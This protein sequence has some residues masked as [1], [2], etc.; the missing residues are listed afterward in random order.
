MACIPRSLIRFL[1]MFSSVL[2][3][4]APLAFSMS[5]EGLL[6]SMAFSASSL[7]TN[8]QS[9]F[10]PAELKGKN[11]ITDHLEVYFEPLR[12]V[13]MNS[14]RIF[15]NPEKFRKHLLAEYGLKNSDLRLKFGINKKIEKIRKQK[16]RLLNTLMQLLVQG[17][18]DKNLTYEWVVS[19]VIRATTQL[20]IFPL[21]SLDYSIS[22]KQ[23]SL[24]FKIKILK[25]MFD[26][27]LMSSKELES[28]ESQYKN[29]ISRS[30]HRGGY[31]EQALKLFP[32]HVILP[33]S[34]ELS[35]TDIGNAVVQGVHYI[36]IMAQEM[37]AHE[38]YF[39]TTDFFAQ[40]DWAHL[41]FIAEKTAG[42]INDLETWSS[43]Q[44]AHSLIKGFIATENLSQIEIE[45]I[46]KMFFIIIHENPS[47]LEFFRGPILNGNISDRI[48]QAYL[49][50]A[51]DEFKDLNL[52]RHRA[53]ILKYFNW[54]SET[55]SA[56]HF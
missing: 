14:I 24:D 33:Y 42:G 5:C 51:Q 20:D 53:A 38:E 10:D 12:G 16:L 27:R 7:K 15:A 29:L 13:L 22:I 47:S 26:E 18:V 44:Q 37:H 52:G 31:A 41:L 4:N 56:Q 54:L 1:L 36:N 11:P 34:G 28:W 21:Q 43:V 49:V 32:Q 46:Q 50:D 45:E 40:H 8:G 35:A 19:T 17:E 23:S 39:Y 30:E 55:D 9:V 6:S 3:L 2:L 48:L 25:R